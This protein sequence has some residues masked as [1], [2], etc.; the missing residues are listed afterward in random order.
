MII[1]VV[2]SVVV[3]FLLL[4]ILLRRFVIRRR[5]RVSQQRQSLGP[6]DDAMAQGLS[7]FPVAVAA[8]TAGSSQTSHSI[9]NTYHSM[10]RGEVRIVIERP[11]VDGQ[12]WANRLWPVPPGHPGHYT[13]ST[14]SGT[15]EGESSTDPNQWS[16]ASQDGSS[17][18]PETATPADRLRT[19]LVNGK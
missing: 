8:G 19:L 6:D 4:T 14:R 11:P 5:Q 10:H 1:A 3:F 16:M 2:I 13:Y 7:H 17:S 9:A 18:L 12:G 15:T